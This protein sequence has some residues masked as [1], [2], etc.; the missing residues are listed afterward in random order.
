MNKF[1]LLIS[2]FFFSALAAIPYA[3]HATEVTFS[4]GGFSDGATV[5]V[6]FSG[7]D[8]NNDGVFSN[9]PF[10]G[11]PS[12]ISNLAVSFS[13]NSIAP[14]FSGN[15]GT[16]YVIYVDTVGLAPTADGLPVI[17][18]G[19]GVIDVSGTAMSG[20]TDLGTFSLIGGA[21]SAFNGQRVI[22]PAGQCAALTYTPIATGIAVSDIVPI[23]EPLSPAIFLVALSALGLAY[24]SPR[25]S[26]RHGTIG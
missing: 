7:T 12:E 8:L 18:A 25:H 13:G 6:S 2:G 26:A 11:A 22:L 19:D 1:K 3:A 9:V 23:P 24:R 21:C 15:L 17:T 14:A 16:Q 4:F 5:S 20:A 10:V